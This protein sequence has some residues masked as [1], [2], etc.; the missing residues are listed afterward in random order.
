MEVAA[1]IRSYCADHPNAADT[2]EGV[3][4]WWLG[5]SLPD[6]RPEL[7]EQALLLLVAE[8][9]VYR[10]TLTDGTVLFFAAGKVTP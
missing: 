1:R 9:S 6:A 8:G 10:R 4:R 3:R 5:A 2:L 7:V